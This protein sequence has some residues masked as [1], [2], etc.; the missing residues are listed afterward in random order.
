VDEAIAA[1]NADDAGWIK[2]LYGRC[3][4]QVKKGTPVVKIREIDDVLWEVRVNGENWWGILINFY[5]SE[6]NC[7][8]RSC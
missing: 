5:N 1:I 2:T 3:S 6:G 4:N 8:N 7:L